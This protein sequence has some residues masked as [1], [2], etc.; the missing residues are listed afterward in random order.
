MNI[1]AG[2]MQ[3]S[4]KPSESE[5]IAAAFHYATH[6]VISGERKLTRVDVEWIVENIVKLK[7]VLEG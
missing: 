1:Q 3:T 6:E 4:S 7:K 2:R 5:A